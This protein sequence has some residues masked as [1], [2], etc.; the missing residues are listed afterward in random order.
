M[1]SEPSMNQA[2]RRL[3]VDYNALLATCKR[4]QAR[5]AELEGATHGSSAG[6]A[7]DD[8]V[9]DVDA[10]EPAPIAAPKKKAAA[11]KQ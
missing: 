9:D 5:I 7:V 8:H 3:Q 11:K 2:Y 6:T 1:P 4:Q 10:P